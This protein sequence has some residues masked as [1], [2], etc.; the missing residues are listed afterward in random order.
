MKTLLKL[1]WLI[2][3]L[4]LCLA[5]AC[6]NDD[7]DDNDAVDDDQADDDALDDDQADDDMADDDVA[8]DDIV[9]DDVAPP[10]SL[11]LVFIEPAYW[12]NK[13][14]AQMAAELDAMVEQGV[15]GVIWRWTYRFGKTT[16]P[17][18]AYAPFIDAAVDDPVGE[19]LALAGQR[20]LQVVLGLSAGRPVAEYYGDPVGDEFAR[21]QTV[22]DELAELYGDHDNLAGFYLPYEFINPPDEDE[23]LLLQMIAA[24]VH[25]RRADWRVSLTLRYPGFPQWWVARQFFAAGW[26]IRFYLDDID[27]TQYRLDWAQKSVDA[28]AEAGIDAL[29]V[30][31]RMGNRLNDLAHAMLDLQAVQQAREQAAAPLAVLVQADLYDTLGNDGEHRPAFGPLND[32]AVDAQLAL[33]ADGHAGFGW[34]NRRNADNSLHGMSAVAEP[35][36]LA[37]AEAVREHLIGKT[38]R[39]RQLVTVLDGQHPLELFGN[40]WQEDACWLTG[41]Y[42]AAESY[43][44]A[45]TGSDDALAAAR[46]TWDALHQMA[47]V[48]PKRGEV[49]RNWTRYLYSQTNPV[50]PTSDTIKR[51]RRHPDKEIYWVGDISIDQLSGYMNGLATY[52]DLAADEDDREEIR[53]ITDAIMGDILDHNLQAVQFDGQYTTYG[54]LA[55][56]P[57]LAADFLLI[58]H[59]ITR[60]QKYL[61]AFEEIT[62]TRYWDIQSILFHYVMHYVVGKTGG[63]HFQDSGLTHMFEYITDE[64][65]YRRWVWELEYVYQGSFLIGNSYANFTHQWHAPDSAGAARA[66]GELYSFDPDLLDN[67]MWFQKIN[68]TWPTGTWVDMGQRPAKEWMWSWDPAGSTQPRGAA[69][70]RY[71]GVGYLLTYWQGRYFGWIR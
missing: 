36:L 23:T 20:G 9:D 19:L 42:L 55:S 39:D 53:S 33:P 21:C 29:L 1:T 71:T 57:E 18:D 44:Y 12:L 37:K 51:W 68:Q 25:A 46:I 47:D 34:D 3:A 32:Q 16:Y 2:L 70:H 66:L 26:N 50:S 22:L 59:H 62:Y 35:E 69:N 67:G 49:V 40:V 54:N 7:D 38:L 15:A 30:S 28:C 65:L 43:H 17:S 64:W 56:S 48:T 41:L 45:V 6:G 60:D 5:L 14:S 4:A 10:L 8:D 63:Q 58:A 61:D 13:D 52:Y 31:T 27:D 24:A 11:D